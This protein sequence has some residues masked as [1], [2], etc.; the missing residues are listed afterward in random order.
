MIIPKLYE[1]QSKIIFYFFNF[2][3]SFTMQNFLCSMIK[4][5]EDHEFQIFYRYYYQLLISL[6]LLPFSNMVY[7]VHVLKTYQLGLPSSC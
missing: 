2:I 1:L 7:T 5:F 6:S 3:P 4:Q